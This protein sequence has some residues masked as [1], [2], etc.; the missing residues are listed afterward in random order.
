MA[1]QQMPKI[2]RAI[3]NI[4]VDVQDI[5]NSLPRNSQ[6]I[7]RENLPPQ[8]CDLDE[9]EQIMIGLTN[10]SD[11]EWQEENLN[12]IDNFWQAPS[13]SSIFPAVLTSEYIEIAPREDKIPEVQF[14]IKIVKN[15]LYNW[16]WNKIITWQIV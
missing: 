5:C 1:K 3:C 9:Y 4:A 15:W 7:N 11:I 2:R 10:E 16:M 13:E 8:L 6:E 14:W 12:R